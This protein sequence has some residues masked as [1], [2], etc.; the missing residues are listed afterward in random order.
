MKI[1]LITQYLEGHGGTERVIAELLNHDLKNDYLVLVPRSGEHPEWLQWINRST[2]QQVKICPPADETTQVKFISKN[3]LAYQP[4]IVLGLEGKAN[5]LAA[6]L[7]QQYQL[8]YQIISWGHTSINETDFFN[9]QDLQFP[10]YHL[11]ISS[12]IQKQLLAMGVPAAKIFLIYNPVTI[13]SHQTIPAP[14]AGQPFHP[15]FI[16]RMILDGQKNIRLLFDGLN[17]LHIPWKL[18]MFGKG[19]DF[20][21]VKQYAQKLGIAANISWH[22]WLP[23]PW[24]MVS[25]ADGLLLSSKY[26]GFPMVLVEAI[27]RGLPVVSTNCP[28]GPQDIINHQNGILTPMDDAPAFAQACTWL[29]LNRQLYKRQQVQQTMRKFDVKNYIRHL[30]EIYRFVTGK[31]Q[32]ITFK[33]PDSDDPSKP[34]V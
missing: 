5:R 1:A 29:Y 10:D 13:I 27:S 26:E 22:G 33:L 12:G 2:G 30:E 28:T 3:L 9:R 14:P 17:L 15:I 20:P 32:K 31:T 16:G 4:A 21:K 34:T 24:Q 11:A 7:R 25:Q 8:D 23:N 6:Q 18:D 19:Y